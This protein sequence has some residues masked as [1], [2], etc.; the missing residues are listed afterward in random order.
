MILGSIFE[1]FY[2]YF[3]NFP[4]PDWNPILCDIVW[5]LVNT[6]QLGILVSERINLKL[7]DEEDKV[8]KNTFPNLTRIEFKKLIRIAKWADTKSN[9][10][11]VEEGVILSKLM[12]IFSGIAEVKKQGY[13][14]AYLR[15]GNFVGEMSFIT[16]NVTSAQV[17]SFTD[18]RY[19]YWEKATLNMLVAK[20]HEIEEGL[21]ASFNLD[22]VKK[23]VKK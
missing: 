16:G 10:T 17:D 21:R 18:L 15:D 19:V 2:F 13:T 22:L 11:L 12:V 3:Y 1:I 14:E 8:F 20:N 6:I 4:K 9:T 5:I 23:L 7:T